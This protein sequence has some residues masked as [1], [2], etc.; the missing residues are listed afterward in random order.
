MDMN[1]I[2]TQNNIPVVVGSMQVGIYPY[3]EIPTGDIK[4]LHLVREAD[5]VEIRD[6]N[7]SLE[8]K[9]AAVCY[10]KNF[11]IGMHTRDCAPICFSD[12]EKIAIA[13]IGWQGYSLGLLE[14]TLSYFNP[15]TVTIYVGPFLNSFEI[16]KDFCYDALVAKPGAEK[17]IHEENG[18]I[19]FRFK[20]AIANILSKETF[21]DTRDTFSDMTL[22]SNRRDKN[23]KGFLTVVSFT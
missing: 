7:E 20:D 1:T 6:G 23:S 3:P 8:N 22:P 4:I 16:K 19:T 21:F 17:F 2:T 15:E 14:K 13:H 18:I 5:I 11:S 10:N 9:D 12:G